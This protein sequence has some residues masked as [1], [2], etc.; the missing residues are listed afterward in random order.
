MKSIFITIILSSLCSLLGADVQDKKIKYDGMFSQIRQQREGIRKHEILNS[1]SPFKEV[2]R[3]ENLTVISPETLNTASSFTL[4]AVMQD[5]VK[6]DGSWY[7]LGDTI[8]EYKIT[9]ITNTS[10]VLKRGD[11]KQEIKIQNGKKNV[12]IKIN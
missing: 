9:K 6:M 4:Q 2:A 12:Y 7:K 1:K 3:D 11:E 5:R 8:G 10:A